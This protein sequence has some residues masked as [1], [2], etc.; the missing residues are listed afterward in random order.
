MYYAPENSLEF[1]SYVF[2]RIELFPVPLYFPI[3]CKHQYFPS[4]F[5]LLAF[6]DK[7]K[8]VKQIVKGVQDIYFSLG[9][10][11]AARRI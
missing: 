9:H 7:K 2:K 1:L 6:F 4:F 8:K 10:N 5:T 3:W 11:F